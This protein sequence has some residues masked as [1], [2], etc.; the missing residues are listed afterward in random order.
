MLNSETQSSDG[1]IF[2]GFGATGGLL[3]GISVAP[4]ATTGG[5]SQGAAGSSAVAAKA[6]SHATPSWVGTLQDSVIKTDMTAAGATGTVTEAGMATLFT[7]L[8]NELKNGN[9][10]LSSSQL[11][12]LKTIAA[13][14]NVG[15]TASG[16]LTY[17]TNA[18]VNENTANTYWTGGTFQRRLLAVSQLARQQRSLGNSKANGSSARTSP[19][20]PSR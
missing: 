14:L 11:S 18:L 3:G 12:D 7:D 16:Y 6:G 9:T 4:N 20:L 19:T 1:S 17:I 8:V 2:V 15:E 10:T 5:N 13:D